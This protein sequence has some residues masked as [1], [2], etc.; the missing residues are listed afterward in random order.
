MFE[1]CRNNTLKI[2]YS[3]SFVMINKLLNLKK[4]FVVTLCF[5]HIYDFL[6]M[7]KIGEILECILSGMD[8]K[9]FQAAHTMDALHKGAKMNS[10][11]NIF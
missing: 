1:F 4:K 10:D 6:V 3:T 7:Y 2:F 5:K 11:M 9:F 8:G